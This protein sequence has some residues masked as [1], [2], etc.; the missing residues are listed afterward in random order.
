MLTGGNLVVSNNYHK[1]VRGHF[2]TVLRDACNEGNAGRDKAS[3]WHLFDG[4][5]NG[6]SAVCQKGV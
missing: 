2:T 5:L 3:G 4:D 1:G 6:K